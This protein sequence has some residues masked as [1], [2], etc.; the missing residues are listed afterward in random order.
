M[1]DPVIIP[2]GLHGPAL[3]LLLCAVCFG[4][5]TSLALIERTG[6]GEEDA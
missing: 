1:P 6:G 4:G 3:Y 2:L 5:M